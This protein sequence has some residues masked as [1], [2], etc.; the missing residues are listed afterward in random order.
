MISHKNILALVNGAITL[1]FKINYTDTYLSYLPLPHIFERA[2]V[3]AVLTSG[4]N[5]SFFNGNMLLLKDDLAKVRP[6]IFCTVPRVLNKF[7][8]I[9]QEKLDELT[10]IKK[11]I[12]NSGLSTKA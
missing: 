11:Y 2:I 10:G 1:D 3:W 8:T 4:A 12:T 6:T 5:I 9:M 7:Y